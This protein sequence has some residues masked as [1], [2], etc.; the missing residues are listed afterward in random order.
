MILTQTEILASIGSESPNSL[1]V[2]PL[3]DINQVGPVALDLRLGY[4]FLVSVQTRNAFV[5]ID[6]SSSSFRPLDSYYRL[7]RRA[8]G[9]SFMLYPNQV[10]L[11]CSLEYLS[12]PNNIMVDIISRSSI[13]RLGVLFNTIIQPGFRGCAALEITNSSNNAIELIVGMR[14]AQARFHKINE[15]TRYLDG[16]DRK[17]FGSI[18][19]SVSKINKDPEIEKLI[20][21]E[22]S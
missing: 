19:P 22:F 6:G 11:S 7:T 3:L 2:D 20:N 8:I 17:Y 1:F 13:N 5:G 18:R 14:I 15:E 9:D 12:V 4:D 21:L 16:G 10:V